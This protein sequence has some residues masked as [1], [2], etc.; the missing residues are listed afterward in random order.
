MSSAGHRVTVWAGLLLIA[1]SIA[2]IVTVPV[3]YVIFS[4]GAA[5]DTLGT[6]G[7]QQVVAVSGRRTYPTD[8][9]MDL[10]TVNV[11]RAGSRIGLAETFSAWVDG[12]RQVQPRPL[13]YPPDQ[14]SSAAE[15]AGRQEMAGSQQAAVVAAAR[16]LGIPV[17][18]RTLISQVADGGPASGR[19]SSGQQIVAVDGKSVSGPADLASS[20]RGHMPGSVLTLRVT[21]GATS[22][23]VPI[24]L[25]SPPKGSP[26]PPGSGYLG[27]GLASDPQAAVQA[28]IDLGQSIGG[29]SAGLMF[30]LAIIDRLTPGTLPGKVHVA[31]TGTI[32]ERGSVGAIG[33]VAEKMLGA[34]AAG[35]TLFLVPAAN[36]A[37]AAAH[38]VDGLRLVRV[39]DLAGAVGAVQAA[40]AGRSAGLPHC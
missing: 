39:S 2:V 40:A 15:Q 21:S 1:V 8:G 4:P 36:C 5:V 37:E 24:R 28:N 3:P 7:G 31:G 34:R 20:V 25:G 12:S 27:I 22:R 33:G 18:E 9:T 35:A 38:P 17:T 30:S 32:D 26:I 11:T 29:P 10:T 23:L 13:V 16:Q 6:V 19:L 14:T